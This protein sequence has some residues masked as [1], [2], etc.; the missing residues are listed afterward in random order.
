MVI[1]IQNNNRLPLPGIIDDVKT[2][3]RSSSESIFGSSE[4]QP[5]ENPSSPPAADQSAIV[6]LNF[7]GAG[8]RY[9]A[10]LSGAQASPELP[11]ASLATPSPQAQNAGTSAA[12][13]DLFATS[14]IPQSMIDRTSL[15]GLG[16]ALSP[17][18][19]DQTF[20]RTTRDFA[21][22]LLTDT[23]PRPARVVPLSTPATV[24]SDAA[25]SIKQDDEKA[26][27][28]DKLALMVDMLSDLA[29]G[30]TDVGKS[31]LKRLTK[32]MKELSKAL[33]GG[34]DASAASPAASPHSSTGTAGP[35][36]LPEARGFTFEIEI[37]QSVKIES[38]V[39]SLTGA[40]FQVAQVQAAAESVTRL[41]ITVGGT[42]RSD[43]VVL[44]LNR[45]GAI[46]LSSILN[47]GG[48]NF[49]INGDGKTERTSFVGGGDGLLALD[50]NGN[51]AIDDGTELFGDQRGAANGMEELRK[52]DANG[53]GRIT[54]RDP[55]F[56]Q[57]SVLADANR[58]GEVG[59]NETRSLTDLGITSLNLN[60][61][62]IQVE[63]ADGNAISAL[64]TAEFADGSTT[65]LADADLTFE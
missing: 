47:G 56:G 30:M 51:G 31:Q 52:L 57:L 12:A 58:D 27:S 24:K 10:L 16:M 59:K 41:R 1:G 46:D 14:W 55:L 65:R 25:S 28:S 50:R 48:E 63:R 23:N 45:D 26:T 8:A 13:G 5:V 53:D 49:D 43:P 64:S 4:P 11:G 42:Q 36:A 2:P 21:S 15:M 39:A 20:L 44:D 38:T 62:S 34:A 18:L 7:P 60:Y 3:G 54:A 40:G 61:Q 37:R 17:R 35:A 9:Q 6:Q 19:I 33:G 22:A 32:L 29:D